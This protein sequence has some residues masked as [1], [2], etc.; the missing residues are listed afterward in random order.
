MMYVFSVVSCRL[1]V[2]NCRG[3]PLDLAASVL[4]LVAALIHD[5]LICLVKV[6]PYTTLC[7]FGLKEQYFFNVLRDNFQCHT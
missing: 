1:M 2:F 7:S 5:Y 4:P 6:D 3:P